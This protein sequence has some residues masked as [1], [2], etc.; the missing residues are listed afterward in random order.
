MLSSHN[1]NSNTESNSRVNSAFGNRVLK[2]NLY[3][4]VSQSVGIDAKAETVLINS[5]TQPMFG[6]SHMFNIIE[7][8]VVLNGCTL[9][10]ELPPN[11]GTNG[12]QGVYVP[13]HFFVDRVNITINGQ[14]F[15]LIVDLDNFLRLQLYSVD[16]DR[17]SS[18]QACGLYSSQNL[19]VN[20]SSTTTNNVILIPLKCAIF[21][22]IQPAILND[23]HA[24]Q[25]NVFMNTQA[26]SIDILSGT[27]T[28][29]NTII[30]S[31]LIMKVTRLSAAESYQ[32]LSLMSRRK[33]DTIFHSVIPTTFSALNGSASSTF[34]LSNLLHQNVMQLII[35]VRASK[36]GANQFAFT[37]LNTLNILDGASNSLTGG[38]L[39]GSYYANLSN[40]DNT[41]SSYNTET[42][43]GLINNQA[44]FYIHSFSIDPISALKNGL[45]YGSRTMQGNE[46]IVLNYVT[47]LTANMIV[48]VFAYCE[49]VCQQGVDGY[50]KI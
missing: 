21:D 42:S 35:C 13:G 29:N 25:L 22:V 18:N 30:S 46:S 14:V 34:I 28:P 2:E 10:L 11:V 27:L 24:I 20:L 49:N 8:N 1:L 31:T 37:R 45:L 3:L 32:R 40:R 44:N 6:S 4:P 12:Y 7:K 36:Q 41:V 26:Q 5:A 16:A 47:P 39:N 33:F 9:R 23:Q 48:D 17:M 15:E 38:P 43:F 19:R 50:S